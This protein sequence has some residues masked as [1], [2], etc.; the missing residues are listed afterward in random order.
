MV[1][2]IEDSFAISTIGSRDPCRTSVIVGS[3]WANMGRH[4]KSVTDFL[5]Y[6]SGRMNTEKVGPV[7]EELCESISAEAF[8]LE[9]IAEAPLRKIYWSDVRDWAASDEANYALRIFQIYR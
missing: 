6:R 5:G 4:C 8:E 2:E 1:H 9:L 3:A 7:M